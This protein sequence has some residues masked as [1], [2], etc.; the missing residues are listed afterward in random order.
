MKFN[1]KNTA[2]HFLENPEE[3]MWFNIPEGHKP[4]TKA[5]DLNLGHSV[6]DAF[7]KDCSIFKNNIRHIKRPFMEA[8][9]KGKHKLADIFTDE[10]L[11]ESG[12]FIMPGD[13]SHYNTI[14]YA[15][16]TRIVDEIWCYDMLFFQFSKAKINDFFSLD[17]CMSDV[18]DT[19]KKFMWKGFYTNPDI[20]I[21]MQSWLVGFL[22]FIKYCDI[23]TKV[24]NAKRREHVAGEKYVN[25]TGFNIEI[26]DCTWFTNIIRDQ[27]FGVS[28]HF[29]FQPHGPGMTKKRLQWISEYTKEGYHRKAKKLQDGQST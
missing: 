22:T 10:P 4:M 28:G 9:W 14:F 6:R 21:Q 17:I 18:G 8:Y 24:V 2:L 5:E 13:G 3:N 20:F 27:Q 1:Y 19:S 11:E 16:K 23:E 25:E 15:I 7:I 29:R 26:V 12:T